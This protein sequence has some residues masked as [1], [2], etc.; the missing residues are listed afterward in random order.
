MTDMNEKEAIE[1]IRE[2]IGK[3][4]YVIP[5]DQTGRV[6]GVWITKNVIQYEVRYFHNGDSKSVYFYEDELRES[7]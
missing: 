7:K 2:P 1:K 3:E 6:T 4:R 5:L